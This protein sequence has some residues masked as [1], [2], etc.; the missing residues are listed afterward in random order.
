MEAFDVVSVTQG[1]DGTSAL[2][3]ESQPE[4]PLMSLSLQIPNAAVLHH[5]SL[6][7]CVCV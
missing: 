1:M 5:S 2:L 3:S 7:S 4:L 6:D